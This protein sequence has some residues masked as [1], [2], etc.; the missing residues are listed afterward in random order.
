MAG[1]AWQALGA[2][3][4]NGMGAYGQRQQ[5]ML[6]DQQLKQQMDTQAIQQKLLQDQVNELPDQHAEG[7]MKNILAMQGENAFNDPQ[8]ADIGRKL[9][10][11]PQNQLPT[12]ARE[13]EKQSPLVALQPSI[14]NTHTIKDVETP[15]GG[16]YLG[17]ARQVPDVGDV[18][19]RTGLP[20]PPHSY[21]FD[22][23]KDW[24][25]G[26]TPYAFDQKT[27]RMIRLTPGGSGGSVSG[28]P[29]LPSTSGAPGASG[30]DLTTGMDPKMAQLAKMV[31]NYDIAP[32]PR[33]AWW[34]TV[35]QAAK[36]INPA[37]DET[38][39]A[40]RQGLRTAYTKGPVADAIVS[41]NKVVN[42]LASLRDAGAKLNNGSL[43]VAN[44]VGNW[45]NSNV[46][47]KGEADAYNLKADAVAE[48][49]MRVF[50]STGAGS[51]QEVNSWREHF[52]SAQTPDQQK[53]V[54]NAGI[55]L[56]LGRMAPV[57]DQ[58]KRGMGVSDDFPIFGPEAQ[59][60]LESFG[61]PQ[62]PAP[63]G[64][65]PAGDFNGQPSAKPSA[66]PAPTAPGVPSAAP[67]ASVEKPPTLAEIRARVQ[68]AMG[69]NADPKAVEA[70]ARSLAQGMMTQGARIKLDDAPT[71]TPQQ[72]QPPPAG[73][74][75]VAA[76][77]TTAPP[78]PPA[79]TASP[80]EKAAWVEA[81]KQWQVSQPPAFGSS[82]F[83][84][85]KNYPLWSNANPQFNA[86]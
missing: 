81:M 21:Q 23:L 17:T 30:S 58:W 45:W 76:V 70:K 63:T 61:Y 79:A 42:H 74:A 9:G 3:L 27:G 43:G 28:I 78:L 71:P 16:G 11:L 47:G 36:Q 34:P 67:T 83:Q 64:G 1:G 18:A 60:V 35:M 52:N 85:I 66:A 41:A 20:L 38:Q 84:A 32:S 48:E 31:A 12:Q 39:Y 49:M 37:F 5:Q 25:G 69:P 24:T 75:P 2:A 56:L 40:A 33:A 62:G 82:V 86:K 73:Q 51:A 68:L 8:F 26:E 4:T 22:K 59:K 53:Q 29:G 46:L 50:R 14:G 55:D 13:V 65:T 15:G 72:P 80:A 77:N 7:K 6:Q 19:P 10:I 57:Q 54:L 44:Q